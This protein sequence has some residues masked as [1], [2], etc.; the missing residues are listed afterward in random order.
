MTGCENWGKINYSCIIAV[1]EI[2][3]YFLCSPK[4][5]FERLTEIL[6]CFDKIYFSASN[7]SSSTFVV[8]IEFF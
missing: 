3:A 8:L 2:L 7:S 4:P 5:F 6:L 1:S